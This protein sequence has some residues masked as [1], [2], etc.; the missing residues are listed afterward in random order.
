MQKTH[1]NWI[2]AARGL[3]ILLVV[4]HHSIQWADSAG[5]GSEV[6]LHITWPLATMRLPLF[7]AV[8]GLLAVKWMRRTFRE[9]MTS[10][11]LTLAWLYVLWQ[12]LTALSY[13]LV[14]NV[15]TP[16]KSNLSEFLTAAATPVLPQNSLWFIWALALFFI[17]GRALYGRVPAWVVLVPAGAVSSLSMAGLIPTGNLGWDGALTNFVFFAAGV[18]GARLVTGFAAWLRTWTALVVVGFWVS[19]MFLLP[20]LDAVGLNLATRALGLAAGISLGVLLQSWALL[21][22]VGDN[23]LTYYLPHYVILGALAFIAS[24]WAIPQTFGA[25]LPAVFFAV[26]VLLCLVLR[27]AAR[28]VHAEGPAYIGAPVFLGAKIGA[29]GDS[30]S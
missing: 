13:L 21:R 20:T 16:G 5:Y 11:V 7:F 26:T 1:Y 23:T 19:S 24:V 14:P 28:L 22:R 3:A 12:F 8:A 10:K 4:L 2:S 29:Y 27:R 15:S 9:L 30:N 18:F 25:W 17:L 6:W